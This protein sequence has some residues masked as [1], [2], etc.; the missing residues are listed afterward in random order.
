MAITGP[1]FAPKFKGGRDSRIRVLG[2]EKVQRQFN[3]MQKKSDSV[4]TNQIHLAAKRIAS[5]ANRD[6]PVRSGRLLRSINVKL[7]NKFAS[8]NVDAPYALFVEKGTKAHT[9]EAKNASVL[10]NGKA[11]FGKKVKHPGTKAQPFILKHV[12]PELKKVGLNIV[13]ILTK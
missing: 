6:V 8:V 13:R 4:M 1:R 9:I 2:L 7:R 11:F 5:H 10:T 12:R 3:K